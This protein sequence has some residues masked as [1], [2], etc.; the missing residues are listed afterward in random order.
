MPYVFDVD[1]A[2]ARITIHASDPVGL[3]DVLALLDQ[4]VAAGAWSYGSLHD[5][6]G[7][8]WLPTPDD[9]RTI[10]AYVDNN[11]RTLGPRGPVA[12][13]A[14]SESL[15]DMAR[16]NSAFVTGSS[17]RAEVFRDVEAAARWLDKEQHSAR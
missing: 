2:R 11:S 3:P 7:V 12:F 10:V 16:M 1:H 8:T 5:A 13:I 6:R 14:A 4:Q 15:F 9:I 17:L